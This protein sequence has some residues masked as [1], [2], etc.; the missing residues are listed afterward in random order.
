MKRSLL[1]MAAAGTIALAGCSGQAAHPN[2]SAPSTAAAAVQSAASAQTLTATARPAMAAQTAAGRDTAAPTTST[3][4]AAAEHRLITAQGIGTVKGTPDT[5]TIV[6]GVQTGAATAQAALQANNTKSAAVIATLKSKGVV[7]A[8]LQTS[9]LSISP[10]SDKSGKITSYQV[11]NMVTVTLHDITAAGKIIDAASGVAGDAIRVDQLGFSIG[12]DSALLASAR[13]DAVRQAAAQAKQ[14]AQAA[15]TK[16]GQVVSITDVP[17]S[18][19]QDMAYGS[20]AASSGAA[21]A[22]I[23]AGSQQLTVAVQVVYAI[24]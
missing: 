16:L 8:D 3:V 14:M 2:N 18:G 17:G 23:E 4:A 11:S 7:A 20:A 22:P 10:S 9:Q 12:D 13:A 19:S 5:V 24:G 6:L 1:T 15:G 21:G